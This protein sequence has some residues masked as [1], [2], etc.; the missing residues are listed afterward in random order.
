MFKRR[1]D[2]EHGAV[3]I[4]LVVIFASVFAFVSIFIDF[5]RMAALQTK[6]EMLARSAV[7]SVLSSFD[8]QLVEKYGLFAYGDTDANYI[9]SKVLQ[10]H[11]TLSKRKDDIPIMTAKLDSSTV[12]LLRPLGSYE[13][14]ERQIREEM[15]YKAPIDFAIEIM[16]RFKPLSNVM[17][18]ASNTVDLLS[19][20]QKLYNQREAKLDE[21]LE[22]QRSAALTVNEVAALIPRS[23]GSS[24]SRTAVS[25]AQG[26]AN[27]AAMYAED[28]YREPEERQYSYE[29]AIY[30]SMTMGLFSGLNRSVQHSS[31]R[32]AILLPEARELLKEVIVINGQMK[33]TIQEAEQRP[34]LGGYND[35]AAY[36]GTGDQEGVTTGDEIAAIREKSGSLLLTDELIASLEGDIERQESEFNSFYVAAGSFLGWEGSV[37]AA[38]ISESSLYAAVSSLSQATSAYLRQYFDKGSGN[39]LE[40]NQSLLEQ[41]RASDRER[42]NIEQQAGTELKEARGLIGR[43]SGLKDKFK[44]VQKQFDQLQIFYNDNLSFN[45]SLSSGEGDGQMKIGDDPTGAGAE[46]MAGMDGFYGGLSR[47]LDSMSD[48]AFQGEYIAHYFSLFDISTL[49][50]LL[51]NGDSSVTEALGDSFTPGKQEI[52]YILYGFHNPAGNIAAAYGEIFTLRLAIR[53]MEGLL[54]N[55]HKG[56]PLLIL[57]SAL[58]YGIQHS[59]KDM[60]MLTKEGSLL[61]SEYMKVRLTYRDHLRIFLL[62]HG[63]SERR[64]SRILGVIRMNTGIRTEQRATYLRGGVTLSMPVWFL[65]GVAKSLGAT[66]VLQGRVEGSRYYVNKQADFSY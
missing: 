23:G 59:V 5:A 42:R 12:E 1:Q 52:E 66:G 3:T 25:V 17:K 26:Y 19:K 64:L 49:E 63:P 14:F 50:Q 53:T 40:K 7:R 38:S 46:A 20:L 41:H 39:I 43:I 48:A 55:L 58:L 31:A 57:A 21:M 29:I 61:L 30:R 16:N 51:R 10:D 27:Y 13:V 36:E 32:H 44:D 34:V 2:A 60:L 47:I 35:V 54:K 65:P 33:S 56:N 22:K 45:Q 62:M 4:F 18:E 15:K 11:M 9:M 28:M 37:L 24:G 8:P 6:T